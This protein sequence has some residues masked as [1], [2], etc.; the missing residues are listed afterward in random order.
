VARKRN[1]GPLNLNTR[2]KVIWNA[3]VFGIVISLLLASHLTTNAA[4]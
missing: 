2:V 1:G 3:L 4:R